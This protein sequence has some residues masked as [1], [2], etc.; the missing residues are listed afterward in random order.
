MCLFLGVSGC[1]HDPQPIQSEQEW[2]RPPLQRPSL[3]DVEKRVVALSSNPEKVRSPIFPKTW[4]P[5]T[6]DGVVLLYSVESGEQGTNRVF[7]ASHRIEL[8][9]LG[10]LQTI[11]GLGQ[12]VIEALGS[13]TVDDV[14]AA[15]LRQA[16][17]A[18]I[19]VLAGRKTVD[20]VREEL[21]A[22]AEWWNAF[23]ARKALIPEDVL[24]FVR[25]VEETGSPTE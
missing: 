18:L 2:L 14:K 10:E 12:D 11:S 3:I 7:P 15:Q 13:E 8:E 9:V 4:P 19:H 22:Y 23:P 24:E 21:R 1:A 17:E 5:Q 25:W 20:S 6:S 16:E